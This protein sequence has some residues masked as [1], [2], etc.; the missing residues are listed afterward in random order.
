MCIHSWRRNI[1]RLTP[2]KTIT[3]IGRLRYRQATIPRIEIKT[4]RRYIGVMIT[5]MGGYPSFTVDF[6]FCGVFFD[7][8]SSVMLSMKGR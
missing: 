7:A 2:R 3:H 5:F 1:A 8:G 6:V 4:N